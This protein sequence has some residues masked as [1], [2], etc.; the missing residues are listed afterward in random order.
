[1]HGFVSGGSS[2]RIFLTVQTDLNEP[3]T[4]IVEYSFER[5][6]LSVSPSSE[7]RAHEDIDWIPL[8]TPKTPANPIPKAKKEVRS[9]QSKKESYA[10]TLATKNIVKNYGNAIASFVLSTLAEPYFSV[11]LKNEPITIDYFKAYVEKNKKSLCNINNFRAMLAEND[12]HS[13]EENACKRVFKR[14]AEIFVKYFS[15]NWIFHGKIKHKEAHLKYRF[16]I[17]RRVRNPDLFTY[18]NEKVRTSD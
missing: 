18:L 2:P 7:L 6:P 1:M 16:K 17:L 9:P 11:S 12:Q 5:R 3:S 13:K 10:K 4:E 8:E 14:L 15:V